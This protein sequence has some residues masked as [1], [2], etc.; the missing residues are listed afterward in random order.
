MQPST[1]HPCGVLKRILSSSVQGTT[2][3]LLTKL[4]LTLMTSVPRGVL[5]LPMRAATPPVSHGPSTPTARP[6]LDLVVEL[7][8]CSPTW[9]CPAWPPLGSSPGTTSA[10]TLCLPLQLLELAFVGWVIGFIC[11]YW[12]VFLIDVCGVILNIMISTIVL[13]SGWTR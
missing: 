10:G 2:I 4:L 11:S 7:A 5:N 3:L 6:C 13:L 8:D 12:L 1:L 9:R